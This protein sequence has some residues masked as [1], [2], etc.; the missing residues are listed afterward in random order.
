MIISRTSPLTGAVNRMDIAVTPETLAKWQN[1][2][3]GSPD[4]L[5]Q[6][7]MPHLDADEREFLI[8]GVLPDEFDRLFGADA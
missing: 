4:R 2:P 5:I 6:N 7:A 1:A 3:M 8:S